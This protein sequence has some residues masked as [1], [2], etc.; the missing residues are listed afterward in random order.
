MARSVCVRSTWLEAGETDD[1]GKIRRNDNLSRTISK[2]QSTTLSA[3]RIRQPTLRIRNINQMGY[4]QGA[5]NESQLNQGNG[6]HR[7]RQGDVQHR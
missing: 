6:L 5:R 4:M 3:E 1:Y 7:N 2:R